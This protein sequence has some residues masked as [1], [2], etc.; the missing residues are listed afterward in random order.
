MDSISTGNGDQG[1][2]GILG[3]ARLDKH[4]PRIE[5][6]GSVD[7]L[8]SEL[9]VCL[10]TRSATG[11]PVPDSIRT[12]LE[13]MQSMLF[14]IG[15]DLA[16]QDC[17]LE[18]GSKP[19]IEQAH[20]ALITGW[21][22]TWEDELPPLKQFILPG[23]DAISAQLHRARTT[24]RRAERRVVEFSRSSGEGGDVIVVLNRFSD[25]LFLQARAANQAVGV[26]DRPWKQ[27]NGS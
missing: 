18:G 2:T 16:Q 24:C 25:L 11:S 9:G 6:Y 5:A 7:E 27:E 14:S 23:G 4:H 10:A 17:G 12:Q 3:A 26:E 15:A 21:I 20:V 1:D 13:Q 22:H 19:R 8:N